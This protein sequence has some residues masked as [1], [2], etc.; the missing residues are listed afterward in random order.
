MRITDI[1][2]VA[3][4]AKDKKILF[5]VD[6]SYLTPFLQRPLELG[7]DIAYQSITKYINGH[8]DIS[9]GS[10]SMNRDDLLNDMTV[11]QISKHF[12][13]IEIYLLLKKANKKDFRFPNY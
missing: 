2:A 8:S 7:A 6:N 12:Q 9:M 3:K 13:F 10:L 11:S 1:S 4:L 5:A